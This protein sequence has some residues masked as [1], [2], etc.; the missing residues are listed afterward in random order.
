MAKHQEEL[1]LDV[2]TKA[3][4]SHVVAYIMADGK[5]STDRANSHSCESLNGDAAHEQI[6]V[7]AFN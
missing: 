5:Y 4:K 3:Q 7:Y 1:F 6:E 2:P